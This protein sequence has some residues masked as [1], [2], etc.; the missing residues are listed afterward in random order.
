MSKKTPRTRIPTF[1]D[2]EYVIPVVVLVLCLGTLGLAAFLQPTGS[3]IAGLSLSGFTLPP[4]CPMSTFSGFPCPGCGL[5]RSWVALLQGNWM[6][7][8]EFH[9]VGWLFACFALLQAL[10]H[11]SW[12]LFKNARSLIGRWGKP[13]DL[14]LIPLSALL[15]L[16]WFSL[17]FEKVFS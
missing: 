1:L 5:T 15:L 9:R 3:K 14:S 13:L 12:L 10:R 11:G 16:N 2:S 6:E 7:S 8:L 4:I 17:M